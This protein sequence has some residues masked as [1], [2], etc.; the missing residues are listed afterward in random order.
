MAVSAFLY[1]SF[2]AKLANGEIDWDTDT[3]KVA[4]LNSGHTPS[5]DSHDYFSD[6]S[7][8]EVTGTGYTAGGVQL[9]N[10]SV[11][12]TAA[13]NTQTFDAD[14]VVWSGSTITA[15]Y[16]VVYVD[17]GSAATSPLI[18]LVDF[19]ED[20]SSNSGDFQLTWNASGIFTFSVA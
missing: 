1:G 17:T 20:K 15:R 13:S 3:V 12:Y 9:T 10:V 7:A 8:N 6:V 2:P 19:G 14:N 18:G 4:L 11:S 16:A 5:Q